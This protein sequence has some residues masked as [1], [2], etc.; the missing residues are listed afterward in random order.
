MARDMRALCILDEKNQLAAFDPR[1]A[2]S[3]QRRKTS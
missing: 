3:R 1:A 2:R